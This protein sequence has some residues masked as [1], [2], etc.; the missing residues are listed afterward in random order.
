MTSPRI[1][2]DTDVV[3]DLLLARQPHYRA[4]MRLFALVQ[5]GRLNGH[6]S[7][8]AFSNLH[9][10]LRRAASG[11]EAVQALRKLRLL[12]GV[13][14]VDARVIDLALASSFSDFEDAIQYFA[15]LEAG[16]EV[17]VTRNQRDYRGSKLPILN[18]EECLVYCGVRGDSDSQL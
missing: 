6:V 2:L 4:T 16:L 17:I 5:E 13:V 14:P 10:L 8:L 3:L 9:Y 15:A 12:V 11:P 18:A 1:L 7:S